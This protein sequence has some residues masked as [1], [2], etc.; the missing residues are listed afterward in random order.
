MLFKVKD[1]L[2]VRNRGLWGLKR[3][4][5][6]WNGYISYFNLKR[7]FSWDGKCF[8][9]CLFNFMG[10][11]HKVTLHAIYFLHAK[12]RD[13][14]TPCCHRVVAVRSFTVSLFFIQFDEEPL[15]EQFTRLWSGTRGDV[16]LESLSSILEIFS[17][18]FPNDSACFHLS[19]GRPF[20]AAVL[21]I[22]F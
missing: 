17:S 8:F 12:W 1:V 7:S 5:R 10:I 22:P 2:H 11:R 3:A 6:S 19:Q 13:K 4:V 16:P 20:Y 21:L 9:L 14:L 15:Y 18:K